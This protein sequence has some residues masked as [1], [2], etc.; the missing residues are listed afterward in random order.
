MT[1]EVL[2]PAPI[3]ARPIVVVGGP[4]GPAGGPTGPTGHTG[5]SGAPAATGPTGFTGPTGA[6]A[7]G[8]S[9]V[10]GP[11][12]LTGYTGP[13]GNSLTGPTGPVSTEP[14]L[15]GPTGNT[16]AG[17]PGPTGPTG[18]TGMTGFGATGPTGETGPSGGPTG[19]TGPSGVTGN[20]GPTGPAITMGLEFVI[21][22]GG[23]TIST[24]VK[25]Y[26][27][28]PFACTITEATLL[29]DQSGSIVVDVWKCTYA[30][31]DAGGTHPVSGDKITASAPPTI[32][33]D[34]KSQDS[35]LSGWTTAVSAGDI[36]AF[37]VN[38]A[39]AVQRATLSLKLTRA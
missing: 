26:V 38:S 10:T 18:N 28:I 30:Q 35:T 11:R 37:N 8:P 15:T 5:P 31:F 34:T 4:T 33:S 2:S 16:G 7:T 24:G 6:G 14:G 13:P 27:E 22:G 20:T 1:V 39:S 25:G 29:A 9:G 12:G 36:L 19:P 21:D 32:S 3:Y 23:S 17:G